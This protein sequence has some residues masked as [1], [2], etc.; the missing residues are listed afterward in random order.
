MNNKDASG[1]RDPEAKARALGPVTI[2]AAIALLGIIVVCAY[3][4]YQYVQ[5]SDVFSAEGPAY[6]KEE[7]P[8][9][10][11]VRLFRQANRTEDP[12][13]RI[14]LYSEAIR[15]K[16]DYVGAYNNRGTV[17]RSGTGDLDAA[18][19]DYNKAIELEPDYATSYYNRGLVNMDRGRHKQALEDFS[20]SSLFGVGR[21]GGPVP[22]A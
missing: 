17:Y 20:G 3:S 8:D 14:R 5:T 11:A 18:L 16:P 10:R 19:A 4:I 22:Q 21:F 9:Q 15:L 12:A 13:E 7:T 1:Q 2:V 6:E